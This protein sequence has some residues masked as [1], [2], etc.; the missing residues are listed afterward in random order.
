ML[1]GDFWEIDNN[2]KL[3]DCMWDK[4][5]IALVYLGHPEWIR[6]AGNFKWFIVISE[7]TSALIKAEKSHISAGGGTQTKARWPYLRIAIWKT[8]KRTLAR[9]PVKTDADRSDIRSLG[10]KGQV[11]QI[12][13]NNDSHLML[14]LGDNRHSWPSHTQESVHWPQFPIKQSNRKSYCGRRGGVAL[15]E[16]QMTNFALLICPSYFSAVTLSILWLLLFHIQ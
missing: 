2:G 4:W 1:K 5:I 12:D 16:S 10:N 3:W 13:T 15:R 7:K 9:V 8:H 11:A 6:N 14:P